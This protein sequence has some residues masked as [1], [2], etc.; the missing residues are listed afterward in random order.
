MTAAALPALQRRMLE[1]TLGIDVIG[2]VKPEAAQAVASVM[3]R[4]LLMAW[5]GQ[6]FALSSEP[7]WVGYTFGARAPGPLWCCGTA[8]S[9]TRAPAT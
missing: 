2:V 3:G 8:C 5:S 9:S 1:T 6:S 4:T 7:I